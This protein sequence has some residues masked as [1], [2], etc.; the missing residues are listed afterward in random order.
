MSPGFILADVDIDHLTE[1][2]LVR[3][4]CFSLFPSCSL[5]KEVA[6][7]GPHLRSDELYLHHLE[8]SPG[9]VPLHPNLFCPQ[10]LIPYRKGPLA[11]WGGTGH[12]R[13]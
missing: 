9:E 4:L 12:S 8:F 10:L 11:S 1:G 3:F 6:M 2:L 7:G 13:R 5:R